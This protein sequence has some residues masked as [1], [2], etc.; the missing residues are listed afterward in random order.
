MLLD[1]LGFFVICQLFVNVGVKSDKLCFVGFLM[2]FNVSYFY[3]FLFIY[4]FFLFYLF[5]HFFC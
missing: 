3:Y 1:N 4:F 5:I 2:F